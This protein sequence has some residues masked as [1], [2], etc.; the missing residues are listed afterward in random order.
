W[1]AIAEEILFAR[2]EQ[3]DCNVKRDPLQ[4]NA[5]IIKIG[6]IT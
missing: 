3:K 5:Q 4:G 2:N 1:L 6:F